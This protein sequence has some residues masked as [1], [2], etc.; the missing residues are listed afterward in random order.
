[1]PGSLVEELFGIGP[2]RAIIPSS[3][4][5]REESVAFGM[6]SYSYLP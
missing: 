3:N 6:L 2:T 5:L 1:M 4:Q